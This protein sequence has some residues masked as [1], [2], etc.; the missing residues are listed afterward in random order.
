M[1]QMQRI[2]DNIVNGDPAVKAAVNR[3]KEEIQQ[4]NIALALEQQQQQESRMLH[5]ARTAQER[6]DQKISELSANTVGVPKDT[7]DMSGLIRGLPASQQPLET[8]LEEHAAV[9]RGG[10]DDRG[11]LMAEPVKQPPKPSKPFDPRNTEAKDIPKE[12]R[13][14][15]IDKLLEHRDELRR[16]E[17]ELRKELET[18]P[19]GSQA[20]I[21]KS[22]AA[23]KLHGEG[24]WDTY[25]I[26][27]GLRNN[28]AGI[29][30]TAN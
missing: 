7:G 12:R 14:P 3:K 4:A 13:T 23:D 22:V 15:E 17:A 28:S 10:F 24:N 25:N 27:E 30:S 29:P 5:T 19:P 1:Q 11:P 20:W 9:A 16:K 2:V 6:R 18:T 8:S 21:D 26:S